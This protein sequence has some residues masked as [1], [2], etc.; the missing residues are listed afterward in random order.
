[1]SESSLIRRPDMARVN[2]DDTDLPATY[3][4]KTV[5]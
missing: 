5:A 1:M 2:L 3:T 4:F